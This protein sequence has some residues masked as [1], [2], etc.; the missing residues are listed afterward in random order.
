[1][2]DRAGYALITVLVASV[3]CGLV[4]TSTPQ[5]QTT[6]LNP[7]N[8]SPAPQFNYAYKIPF[9]GNQ[10]F[11]TDT[12]LT[13]IFQNGTGQLDGCR[14][15]QYNLFG[16]PAYASTDPDDTIIFRDDVETYN[17]HSSLR[18]EPKN[19]I[20]PHREINN[21]WITTP[22]GTHIVF[23]CWVKTSTDIASGRAGIIGFDAFS[24]SGIR[25]CEVVPDL[26]GDDNV[27]FNYPKTWNYE[28]VD[29]STDWT[30]VTIDATIPSTYYTYTYKDVAVS[31]AVQI[32]G[33][34]PFLGANWQVGEDEADVWFADAE[35]YKDPSTP[36]IE[37]VQTPTFNPI[38]GT[39]GSTQ[40]V[41]ISSATSDASIYY[42]VDGTTPTP[43]TY[44]Y[45]APVSVAATTTLKALGVKGGMT[46]SSVATALYTINN[47]PTPSSIASKSMMM[48]LRRR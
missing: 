27:G 28:W 11:M 4:Y 13:P 33:I 5:H 32:A 47:P 42:T 22:P 17:G 6:E 36:F 44:L 48:R 23:R 39:Y 16:F 40:S 25:L 14:W 15:G 46:D 9:E 38:Q 45:A 26:S 19:L 20:N 41:A 18:L 3:F 29:Y 8:N 30:Q 34:I 7:E 2:S 43:A 21:Y 35:L 24:G 31:P 1:M 37:Q 12:N 10:T